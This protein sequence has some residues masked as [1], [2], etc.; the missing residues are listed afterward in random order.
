MTT[1]IVNLEPI[2]MRS[3]PWAEYCERCPKCGGVMYWAT[4]EA[5]AAL[6]RRRYC[7]VCN[8]AQPLEAKP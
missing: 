1:R 7:K 4:I 3:P 6:F 8:E 5:A 2:V